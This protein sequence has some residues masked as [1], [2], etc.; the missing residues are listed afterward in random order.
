M[1][2]NRAF[3]LFVNRKHTLNCHR[4]KG[5]LFSVLCEIKEKTGEFPIDVYIT[6]FLSLSYFCVFFLSSAIHSRRLPF[7]FIF[8]PKKAPRHRETRMT[9]VSRYSVVINCYEGE[10]TLAPI[11]SRSR[12]R[13]QILPN[14]C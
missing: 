13:Y 11:E 3:Y 8:L 1:N 12:R 6:I 10:K 2:N 4:M 7:S 5:A 14:G 9:C